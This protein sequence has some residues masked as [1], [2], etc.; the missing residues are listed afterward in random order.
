MICDIISFGLWRSMMKNK[1]IKRIIVFTI[2]ISIVIV[3]VTFSLDA[4]SSNTTIVNYNKHPLIE[5]KD[6]FFFLKGDIDCAYHDDYFTLNDKLYILQL[7]I[8]LRDKVLKEED[9]ENFVLMFAPN[10]ADV[11]EDKL[12]EKYLKNKTEESKIIDLMN[13][14]AKYSNIK[15]VLATKELKEA[16]KVVDTYYKY[17]SHWNSY[18]ALIGVNSLLSKL[19]LD[20]IDYKEKDIT[21]FNYPSAMG[22]SIPSPEPEGFDKIE[23]VYLVGG[24]KNK[25]TDYKFILKDNKS[26]DHSRTIAEGVNPTS[27]KN[28]LMIHDSMA[29]SMM[30]YIFPYFNKSYLY[31]YNTVKDIDYKN[32]NANVFVYELLETGAYSLSSRLINTIQGIDKNMGIN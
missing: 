4:T 27:N 29:F 32:I 10:K 5:G 8:M 28:I 30:Q 17:D 16:T 23:K 15:V 18:G 7:L 6:R 25:E 19:G 11:Y 22:D 21:F 13:Y 3:D 2:L 9:R 12:D 20:T 26:G 31:H 1:V 24:I 14:I